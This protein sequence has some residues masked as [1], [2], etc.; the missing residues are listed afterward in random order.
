M[1]RGSL[2]LLVASPECTFHSV[3][4]GGRPIEDQKHVPAWGVIQW[5]QELYVENIV[6][7]NVSEF[8]RWGPLGAN[9]KPLKSKIG[10]TYQASLQALRSLGYRVDERVICC[11][12][13]EDATTRKRLFFVATRKDA[14]SWPMPS[15]GP[16]EKVSLQTSLFSLPPLKPWRPGPRNHRLAPERREYPCT[17]ETAGRENTEADRSGHEE[18]QRPRYR[19]RTD[20]LRQGC[21][22]DG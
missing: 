14:S 11:A 8:V 18:N 9:G 6:I 19:A 2:H 20:D 5:A 1:P 3:A 17:Q 7:E 13:Y 16:R 10:E 4:R 15:H 21:G 22:T 12:D